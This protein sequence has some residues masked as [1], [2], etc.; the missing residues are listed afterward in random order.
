MPGLDT[1][2]S[3]RLNRV[4]ESQYYTF[5]VSAASHALFRSVGAIL[6]ERLS[7]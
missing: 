6:K 2:R 7:P 1:D 3:I 4:A 5:I